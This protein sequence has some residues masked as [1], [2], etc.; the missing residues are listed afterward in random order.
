MS[1]FLN[2]VLVPSCIYQPIPRTHVSAAFAA[3]LLTAG[4]SVFLISV[5]TVGFGRH[6][7]TVLCDVATDIS[8]VVLGS[9]W[10]ALFRDSLV[11]GGFR[12]GFLFDPWLMVS[13]SALLSGSAPIPGPS[14]SLPLVR[15]ST[16]EDRGPGYSLS[17]A[18]SVL[19][20]ASGTRS[21]PFPITYSLSPASASS[22]RSHAIPSPPSPPSSSPLSSLPFPVR[23]VQNNTLLLP[24]KLCQ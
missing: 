13:D 16:P 11:A 24:L 7:T 15:S 20:P 3:S 12:P 18:Q 8:G 14:S 1:V 2:G 19:L 17:S 10:A 21:Q 22:T 23:F 9:D 5:N 4:G 6:S